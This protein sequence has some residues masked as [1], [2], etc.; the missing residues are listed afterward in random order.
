MHAATAV[1]CTRVRLNIPDV[2]RR[3][4]LTSGAS[5][6]L[7][8]TLLIALLLVYGTSK[9]KAAHVLTVI[10]ARRVALREDDRLISICEVCG[11]TANVRLPPS[12]II[13]VMVCARTSSICLAP[14][15]PPAPFISSTSRKSNRA[16]LPRTISEQ[17]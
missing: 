16:N 9:M 5:R 7:V 17:I 3:V 2:H 14:D 1:A 6:S 12:E 4:Q 8:T 15:H 11:Q 10:G 13:G